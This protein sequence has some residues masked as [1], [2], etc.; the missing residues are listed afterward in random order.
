MDGGVLGVITHNQEE[1]T[2]FSPSFWQQVEIIE[3]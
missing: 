1:K 2:Y 3:E